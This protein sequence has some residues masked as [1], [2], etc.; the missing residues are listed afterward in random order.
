VQF[1]SNNTI[2]Q[3]IKNAP[4][5]VSLSSYYNAASDNPSGLSSANWYYNLLISKV[6]NQGSISHNDFVLLFYFGG[7]LYY[8][9]YS[10]NKIDWH[11][12]TLS[13]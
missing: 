1:A 11:I 3:T 5:G 10:D 8:G 13:E 7:G 9:R 4:K 2:L 6:S 12:I